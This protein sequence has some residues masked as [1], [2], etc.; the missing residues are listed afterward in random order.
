MSNS[1]SNSEKDVL[2][3]RLRA[4]DQDALAE[5]IESI[6][7]QLC[8]YIEKNMSATLKRKLDADDLYQETLVSCLKAFSEVDIQG[9]DPFHWVC[10]VAQRRI[11]DAG[12]KYSGTQKR[13]TSRETSIELLSSSSCRSSRTVRECEFAERIAIPVDHVVLRPGPGPM[14]VANTATSG[15]W[16][17]P[18]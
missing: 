3:H 15:V 8:G 4:G 13:D 6:R 16:S 1:E 17:F 7:P 5:Y 2:L 14:L 11:I 18:V 10:Q 12:R 9:N